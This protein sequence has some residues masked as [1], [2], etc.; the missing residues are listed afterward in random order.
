MPAARLTPAQ[1]DDARRAYQNDPSLTTRDLAAVYGV[2]LT[3]MLNVLKG[4][5]RPVGG[6]TKT[7]TSTETMIRMRDKGMTLAQI[8]KQVGLTESGVYRRIKNYEARRNK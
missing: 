3:T 4:V 8:G 2:S 6:Q 1:K 7:T 5:T